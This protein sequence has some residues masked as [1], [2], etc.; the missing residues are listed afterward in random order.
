MPALS[1]RS[2]RDVKARVGS[3]L[4]SAME[5][6]AALCRQ[7]RT[8]DQ[9][10]VS[11]TALPELDALLYAS[12]L[13]QET[14]R[15]SVTDKIGDFLELVW[16]LR[17]LRHP[18][19][20]NPK[21]LKLDVG[22]LRLRWSLTLIVNSWKGF[23]F[24]RNPDL[25]FSILQELNEWLKNF[26]EDFDIVFLLKVLSCDEKPAE[27]KRQEPVLPTNT[28]DVVFHGLMGGKFF[29]LHSFTSSLCVMTN[30]FL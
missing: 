7:L 11:Q 4:A 19:L 3:L 9:E 15:R 24:L 8:E 5:T 26:Y 14:S 29:T 17:N 23:F 2:Q 27:R 20:L 21:R 16:T 6:V 10:I 1:V 12:H 25:S 30:L 13:L 18:I 22:T 28:S